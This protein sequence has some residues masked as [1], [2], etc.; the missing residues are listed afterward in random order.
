MD[1]CLYFGELIFAIQLVYL[2]LKQQRCLSMHLCCE[3]KIQNIQLQ[4]YIYKKNSWDS[5]TLR[6]RMV[7]KFSS[8]SCILFFVICNIKKNE[9][10]QESFLFYWWR[11]IKHKWFKSDVNDLHECWWVLVLNLCCSTSF[12]L[13][14]AKIKVSWLNGWNVME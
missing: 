12:L 6:R 11:I 1:S 9:D 13:S 7:C 2:W 3:V 10:R 14:L 4:I 5:I 8:L